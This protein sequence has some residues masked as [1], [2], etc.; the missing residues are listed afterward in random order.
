MT[1][2]LEVMALSTGGVGRHV[3]FL[4]SE[5]DGNGLTIDVA[6]PAATG[7]PMPR[8]ILPVEIPGGAGPSMFRATSMMKAKNA[9]ADLIGS[10]SYDVVHR[11]AGGDH[12]AQPHPPRDLGSREECLLQER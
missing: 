10:G 9:L 7:I 5:L 11:A 4:A 12:L 2:V 1:K 3:A 6:A 8:E